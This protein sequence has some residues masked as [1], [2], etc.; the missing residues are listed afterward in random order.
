M[1][2]DQPGWGPATDA[3]TFLPKDELAVSLRRAESDSVITSAPRRRRASQS[4]IKPAP[5]PPVAQTPAPV[6]AAPQP[7][8][9]P[10]PEQIPAF[11]PFEGGASFD[12]LAIPLPPEL[13]PSIYSWLRRLALQ[14]E[15]SGADK[16]LREAFADLTNALSVLIIYADP[17]GLHSLGAND[18]MPKDE[19]PV[20][21]VAKARR[22]L[23]GTHSALIPITT[24]TETIAVIQLVRNARQPAFNMI[25]HVT[26]AALARESA[27]IMHHLV[28]QHLQRRV[29]HEADKK[30]LYR[31][32]ALDSHRRRGQE[33]GVTE[34]SPGWV[35]R[36]YH[37]LGLALVIAIV[38][39]IFVEVPTYSSGSGIVMYDGTRVTAPTPGT[40]EKVF[41]AP[42]DYVYKG[43]PLLKLHSEAEESALAQATKEY[44]AAQHQ[45]LF[46]PADENVKKQLIASGTAAKRAQDALEQKTV[47]ATADGWVKGIRAEAGKPVQFGDPILT[48]VPLGAEPYMLAAL[49]GRDIGRIKPGQTLQVELEGYQKSR[50]KAKIIEVGDQAIGL[51][52]L[53]KTLGGE[54]ADSLKLAEGSYVIIK[55]RLPRDY[56]RYKGKKQSFRFG[57][58]AKTEVRIESKRFLVTLLPSLE[59]YIE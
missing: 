32:E 59:K 52:E 8:P 3:P 57:M 43:D 24:S 13:A 54:Y 39:A 15:L 21:A 56:F 38:F 47:R 27:S 28:V 33:G 37:I 11:I 16:L 26:M 36:T 31:P 58:P 12:P 9:A 23:V 55:A 41:V 17:D 49:P 30:S 20:V 34:L 10:A 42:N 46:D 51:A 53:R 25:D 35:R 48:L 2:I 14:A 44:D 29:E 6:A 40:V 7:A 18:E 19:Q 45:F 5:Q 22:A 50:E 4:T 1:R